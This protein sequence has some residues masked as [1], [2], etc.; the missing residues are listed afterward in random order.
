MRRRRRVW[1]HGEAAGE[2]L[3]AGGG[4]GGGDV[5]RSA[6]MS[7]TVGP[8]GG[9]STRRRGR[10]GTLRSSSAVGAAADISIKGA[11]GRPLLQMKGW[12]MSVPNHKE[13]NAD[14]LNDR[15]PSDP[16]FYQVGATFVSPNDEHY[17]G[18]GQNHEGYLDR[19]GH[20]VRCAHDYTAPAGPSVCVPFVVTN[21]G[22]GLMWDN[23]GKT[24]VAVRL[25]RADEVDLGCG[26]ACVVFCDR[27]QDV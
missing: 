27:G 23:P 6:R 11:D 10:R 12:E 4:G 14:I 15:R 9:R 24:T 8:A 1:H 25:Q 22:Y 3:D 7:V 26:A 13:G 16:P 18:M 20:A 2:R 17:Y 21:K 5:L 19:R